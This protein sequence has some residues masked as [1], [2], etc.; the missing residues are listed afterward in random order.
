MS[1]HRGRTTAHDS[2][3]ARTSDDLTAAADDI[4]SAVAARLGA[5]DVRYTRTRRAVVDVLAQS[6]QPL[7]VEQIRDKT[8]A[9]LSSVYR[10][11]TI[12]GHAELVH[13]LT[14]DNSEYAHYELA[15]QLLGHHHHLACANCGTMTDVTLPTKLEAALDQALGLLATQQKFTLDSHRLDILGTC[16]SCTT[17]A[18]E[19]SAFNLT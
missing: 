16:A 9:P 12:L 4:H 7:T 3:D 14:N 6:L 18:D 10:T 2:D 8:A 17:S 13:R 19:G 5:D 11:L 15:E 1:A